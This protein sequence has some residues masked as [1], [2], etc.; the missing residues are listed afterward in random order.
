MRSGVVSSTARQ[1]GAIVGDALAGARSEPRPRRR[2]WVEGLSPYLFVAPFVVSFVVLF[3]GPAVYSLVLSFY[4]Y[5]GYGEATWVGT[6]NYDRLLNYHQFWTAWR[7][8]II[9]WLGSASLTL[10][11][12]FLL[13]VLVY[14]R[15]I[16]GKRAYKPIIFMPHVIATVAA[17]LVFQTIFSPESGVLNNLIGAS[18]AW[19]QD[20]MLGKLAV[21]LLRSWH[22]VGWFFVIFLA[23]LTTINPELYDAA[24]V[25]G[26]NAWQS[27]RSITLPLMRRTV[28]FAVVTMSIYSLRMFAEPNL[29]FPNN[30]APPEFQPIMSQLYQNMRGGQFGMSSAVAWLIFVPVVV[31][32]V[33]QFRLLRG[34]DGA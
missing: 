34:D 13:A 15:A 19:D 33:V 3:V 1:T 5:R 30:L 17:A 10:V 25:D 14:S 7:N 22:S 28:L 23:G 18:L 2:A 24:K 4:R 11:T 21:I 20:P 8:T 16:K 12:A 29:L 26:A 6:Q 31:V 27:L 9:Y 32:S